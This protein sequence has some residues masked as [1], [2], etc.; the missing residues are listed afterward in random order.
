MTP[1]QIYSVLEATWPA[2]VT[3]R[4]GPWVVRDG[5]GGGKRVSAATAD[6]PWQPQDIAQ[7]EGAML[8]LGQDRL[9]MIRDGEAELDAELAA[10]GYAIVD[11]VV[12]YAAPCAALIHPEPDPMTG[13]PHW[14]P[15]G[16]ATDLWAEAGTGPARIA[17]MHRVRGPKS[18]IL[19][20][21][22]DRAAGVAFVA[23]QGDTAMLHALEVAP[24]HRRKGAA[25]NMLQIA[26]TWAQDQGA[27]QFALVVTTANI[28]ARTL[29]A[30]LQMQPVG[31]YH[32][33]LK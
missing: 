29:Y 15:L 23:L 20:R 7:A 10:Q 11:P 24:Q 26:A 8:A 12:A 5:Q 17:I 31:H 19:G 32:Y 14:P 9:F 28:A 30:S 4:V 22:D 3:R 33:R 27:V 1:A 16:I 21:Q 6:A 2:A 13:F 18:V 25:R